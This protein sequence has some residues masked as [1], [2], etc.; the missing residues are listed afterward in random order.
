MRPQVGQLVNGKYRLVR[1]LGDGGMG[2]VFQARHEKLGITVA[3]KFLHVELAKKGGLVDRFLQEARASAQIQSPF[4]VRVSDVDQT[5]EGN[6]FIVLEYLEGQT[7]QAMYEEFYRTGQRLTYPEALAFAMQMIEGLDAAHQAGVIHRDLKP[8]NVMVTTTMKGEKCLKILDFGIAKL[9]VTGDLPGGLTK[10]GVI[11]GTPEYMA[12]EQAYSADGVDSRADIFSL[13]VILFE[14]LAGRRPV[15]GDEPRQIANAYLSGQTAKLAD[16]VPGIAPELAAIVH[17]AMAPLAKDRFPTARD[18]REAIEPFAEASRP[19][20]SVP[21]PSRGGASP[22]SVGSEPV[23]PPVKIEP[24]R[25]PAKAPAS[26]TVEQPPAL[27]GKGAGSVAKTWPPDDE[28]EAGRPAATAFDPEGA[29]PAR[30]GASPTAPGED[31]GAARAR[32][33]DGGLTAPM[34]GLRQATVV[35]DGVGAAGRPVIAKRIQ[36]KRRK[37]GLSVP[38][39]LLIALGTA[40]AALGIVVLINQGSEDDRKPSRHAQTPSPASA[41]SAPD[42]VPQQPAPQQPQPPPPTPPPQAAP[43]PQPNTA[44]RPRPSSSGSAGPDA[45]PPPSG[46][47]P[48][49]PA[50]PPLELPSALPTFPNP[51]QPPQ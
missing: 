2:S 19:P 26:G 38:A 44:P 5:T 7:L 47:P 28:E 41:T 37:R 4:V 33:V 36:A 35:D 8:D 42:P 6:A 20:S 21:V 9:K 11:M 15:A 17:R 45:P 46:M 40:G 43:R 51:F 12:P 10:P 50:L 27:A 32:P 1:L 48:G 25:N 3:L 34:S 31:A 18:L 49:M 14:M 16:I 22:M 39:I 23:M 24:H 13:G 29:A 30:G